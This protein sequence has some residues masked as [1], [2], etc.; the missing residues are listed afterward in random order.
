MAIQS[1]SSLKRIFFQRHIAVPIEHGSWVFLLGPILVGL[2]VS[3]GLTS[4]QGWVILA[5]LAGFF[6]RQPLT[7]LVKV[8]SGRRPS[9]ERL[10]ALFWMGVYGLI[11]LIAILGM[12]SRGLG[13][14]VVLAL[15]ALPVLFWHLWLVSRR[16]ERRKPIVEIAG[17][18]VLGL[19]AP[20]VYWAGIGHLNLNGW[21]LWLLLWLQAIGS[22]LYAY[23]RL[24]QR[25]WQSVPPLQTRL[26]AARL[27]LAVCGGSI[28]GVGLLALSGWFSPLVTAAYLIQFAEAVWGALKPAIGV[29]PVLIGM[30]QLM[31][32]S[33]FMISFALLWRAAG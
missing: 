10:P 15:P 9:K 28:A 31:I 7:I 25:E 29:K 24:S 21:L 32:S 30:R 22:I 26:S 27:P 3:E 16:E 19:A 8:M 20:A 6:F 1:T 2:V 12:L 11:G 18:G 4:N 5:A 23:L 14:L 13:F 33:L 17:S